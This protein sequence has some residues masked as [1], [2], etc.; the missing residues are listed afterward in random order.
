MTTRVSRHGETPE[1]FE[2]ALHVPDVVEQVGNHDC[3]ERSLEI[4][5]VVR[6]ALDEV[7]TGVPRGGAPHHLP[8]EVDAD[9]ERRRE[10]GEEIALAAPDLDHP[11]PC[12]D[13][14]AVNLRQPAVVAAA[15]P[16]AAVEPASH[17]IPV[18]DPRCG[19]TLARR[20]PP[21]G[22]ALVLVVPAHPVS[23]PRP[24]PAA[25]RRRAAI[26]PEA[27]SVYEPR[28]RA[29]TRGRCGTIRRRSAHTGIGRTSPE[30]ARK[31]SREDVQKAATLAAQRRPFP[32]AGRSRRPAPLLVTLIAALVWTALVAV[33]ARTRYGSDVRALILIGEQTQ[34]PPAFAS[35]PTVG[36]SGYDGAFYAVL[37]TDPLLRRLD[38]PHYLDAPSY[39]A[40]RIMVPLLAWVL[41]LGH[42]PAA[43]VFY[44]LLCWGLGIGAVY[45]LARWLADEGRSPWWALLAA[46]GGGMAAAILRSTPDAAALFF[47]LAALWLHARGRGGLALA[48][49]ALAVLTRETSAL[50]ALAI[51]ADELRTR[52]WATAA[53]FV[54][55]PA[56]AAAGWQ[57]YLRHVLGRAFDTASGSFS[58]PFAWLPHKCAVI[59]QHGIGWQEVFGTAAI[60]ATTIAFVA[61]AARPSR[62]RTAEL[63]F[64][65][66]AGMG[67]FLGWT[68]YCEAW[69]YA[70]ALIPV[71]FLAA[72]IGER[73]AAGRRRWALRSVAVFYFLAG[74]TMISAEVSTA[75]GGRTFADAVVQGTPP[76]RPTVGTF[77]RAADSAPLLAAQPPLWVLPVANTAGRAGAVWRTRLTIENP[78]AWPVRVVIELLGL[79]RGAA[80]GTVLTLAA[81]ETRTWD[82]AL[83]ELFAR[84]GMGALRLVAAGWR[85]RAWSL[86]SNV[87]SAAP[88]GPLLPALRQGLALHPGERG[89][90]AG[91]A[92][93][94]DRGAGVR[95]NIGLLNLAD[96][97]VTVRIE[98]WDGGARR[99]G[100]IENELGPGV[101]TQVDDLFARVRAPRLGDGRAVVSSPTPG[102]ALL[103]YAS[104]I[105]GRDAQPTYIVLRPEP[106]P[107][108]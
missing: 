27:A 9:P 7:Q 14:R 29:V 103:V 45:L 12:G 43:I 96:R 105:R 36:P 78:H 1:L 85:V 28:R 50:A 19:V 95:T 47:M 51:A 82:N 93:D 49:A 101:M 10:R 80:P 57:L 38:T 108:R 90:C 94:P 21:A 61:V 6:V 104:V 71:P 98:A 62:W 58:W 107:G 34:L 97:P 72:L 37:A 73:Q 91:L 25:A 64:L 60:L 18:L 33:V 74:V 102:A 54:G 100:V 99:L 48:A 81:H 24:P 30:G 92:F 65:A 31:E 83:G 4:G 32:T 15:Q 56:V 11:P 68:V 89:S 55:V 3:V 39:R 5:Q 75:L 13:E 23:P 77:A 53:A 44:Q 66:F 59:V 84:S 69:A 16:A 87:A 40:T 79:A 8:R 46:G 26:T 70:R 106:D 35:I 52:R 17:R 41:A 42:A 63:T 2:D 67:L 22:R 20:V 86:T 88:P 76:G